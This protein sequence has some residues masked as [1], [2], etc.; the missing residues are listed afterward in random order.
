[1]K[2]KSHFKYTSL[3]KQQRKLL[4]FLKNNISN[5]DN[6]FENQDYLHNIQKYNN[7]TQELVV[8]HN[9]IISLGENP[10]DFSPLAD[11]D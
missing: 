8:E 4:G 1:M 5:C 2:M 7:V 11:Y 9:F 10:Y 6:V 3:I